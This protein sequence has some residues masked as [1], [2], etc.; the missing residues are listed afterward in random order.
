[1]MT[2]TTSRQSPEP[3]TDNSLSFGQ[4]MRLLAQHVQLVLRCVVCKCQAWLLESMHEPLTL[5][6]C[7]FRH[8]H[9]R[10]RDEDKNRDKTKNKNQD[11]GD[12]K[13]MKRLPSSMCRADLVLSGGISHE[14]HTERF[15]SNKSLLLS[16]SG[17]VVG[18]PR[19]AACHPGQDLPWKVEARHDIG[20]SARES[21]LSSF[22]A[23]LGIESLSCSDLCVR[24]YL[25]LILPLP[26]ERHRQ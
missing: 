15:I 1:M 19:L 7:N 9:D 17:C 11:S 26:A 10:D 22:N 14:Q 23:C 12:D 2:G 6:S 21:W 3:L 4:H 16:D 13:M 24:L 25:S 8:V 5:H 18:G 20:N